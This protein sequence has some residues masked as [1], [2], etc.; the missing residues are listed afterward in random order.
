MSNQHFYF[1]KQKPQTGGFT[2]D[3]FDCRSVK[4]MISFLDRQKEEPF[5]NEYLTHETFVK[6]YFDIDCYHTENYSSDMDQAIIESFCNLFVSYFDIQSDNIAVLSASGKD[7]KTDMTKYSYHFTICSL[8]G[9]KMVKMNDIVADIN[10]YAIG[11]ELDKKYSNLLWSKNNQKENQFFDNS[12]YKST[13]NFRC[14]GCAKTT[15]PERKFR[16]IDF[17]G[18]K[19]KFE[20]YIVQYTDSDK[21]FEWK[22]KCEKVKTDDFDGKEKSLLLTK[23]EISV[24]KSIENC[25]EITKSD[26]ISLLKD[27]RYWNDSLR[28]VKINQHNEVIFKGSTPYICMVCKREHVKFNNNSCVRKTAEGTF[29]VCRPGHSVIIQLN[30]PK[31]VFKGKCLLDDVEDEDPIIPSVSSEKPKNIIKGKC[32]LDDVE[33]ED[34]IVN[35]EENISEKPKNK[36]QLKTKCP[37]IKKNP[38]KK[39]EKKIEPNN[40]DSLDERYIKEN[41]IKYNKETGKYVVIDKKMLIQYLNKFLI[42]WIG[43][44]KPTVIQLYYG[45]LSQPFVFRRYTSLTG[46]Y[47]TIK[48]ALDAWMYSLDR[49]QVTEIT[50]VPYTLKKPNLQDHVLNLFSEFKHKVPIDLSQRPIT[51]KIAPILDHIKKYW[52]KGD[53]K[54]YSYII[55]WFAHKVQIP[56]EKIAT[57]LV[58]KSIIQG[59]GKN[60]IVNYF[61][62]YV[63]GQPFCTSTSNIDDILGK[64]NAKFERVILVGLD[65]AQNKGV[66]Y[67][68]SDRLKDIIDRTRK[69]IEYKGVDGFD[70]DDYT[71]CIFTSNCDWVVKVE[72]SC[73]RYVCMELDCG[74]VYIEGYFK[75]IKKICFNDESGK[76]MFEYLL[77]YDISE[78]ESGKIPLTEW[79]RELKEKSLDP[80]HKCIINLIKHNTNSTVDKWHISEFEDEYNNIPNKKNVVINNLTKNLTN[81]LDLKSERFVKDGKRKYGFE[82][83][84]P[85][86][87]D[88]MRKLLKD[89]DYNFDNQEDL[90]DDA[91]ANL[92]GNLDGCVL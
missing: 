35:T 51:P 26:A 24:D 38:K 23:Q 9:L 87:K 84:I 68:M 48:I 21:E 61:K 58:L 19:H 17:K 1:K 59:A 86:L 37:T 40:M 33:D 64:F 2:I 31:E 28:F 54:L 47:T 34:S 62:E 29:F 89:P 32:L 77:T 13:Q 3:P 15:D 73:R 5:L 80:L 52:C 90:G 36:I 10:K 39:T 82:I 11:Q 88:K 91:I 43:S 57:A 78:W 83:T 27:A 30:E 55:S 74:A 66:A 44:T 6:P 25:I 50:W 41:F 53:E 76:E 75:N 20:D 85:E 7:K 46:T 18:I 79:K 49:R 22:P 56:N 67:K 8:G 92:N 69:P 60:I 16:A 81:M 42:H 72:A 71:D 70:R 65:E 4:D 14:I 63:L 12:V 45:S